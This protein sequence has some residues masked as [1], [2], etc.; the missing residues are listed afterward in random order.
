[1][2]EVIDGQNEA[3]KQLEEK[4]KQLEGQRKTLIDEKVKLQIKL[5]NIKERYVKYTI[6]IFM[7][8]VK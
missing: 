2:Q 6:L 3:N 4:V 7:F 5:S 8:E 1:M